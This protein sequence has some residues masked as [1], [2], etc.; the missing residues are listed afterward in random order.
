MEQ[1]ARRKK[2]AILSILAEADAPMGSRSIAE[3]LRLLGFDLKERMVRYYLTQLDDQGLTEDVGRAGRR[4]TRRGMQD[5]DA[6]L[7]VEKVGYASARIDELA[8]KMTFS[9]K[10]RRGSVVLNVSRFRAADYA[11]ASN[12]IGAVLGRGLGMGT[13][14]ALGRE[15]ESLG[16]HRIT[17][18][19]VGI[20]TVCSVTLNGAFRAAGIPI[21]ARLGGLLELSDGEP[22][23]FTQIIH[24]DGTTIDPV[25]VFLKGKLTRV[26]EAATT[27][28]G[29]IGAGFR[30]IPSAALPEARE[31]IKDLESAGLGC[32]LALGRPGRTLLGIPVCPGR[33]GIV[34]AAGL[35]AIAAVEEAGIETENHAMAAM[36]PFESLVPMEEM[37]GA[38][39]TSPELKKRL[40]SML[41]H[42]DHMPDRG[43]Y[44]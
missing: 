20:G 31:V 6:A 1:E 3:E 29:V 15:G 42:G 14:V 40:V 7:A 9:P 32:I 25:L 38:M 18:G 30:E 39:V 21:H 16:G 23:R 11:E 27:G 22:R 43:L 4:I 33:A 44:E 41:D 17:Y 19:E 36:G 26:H 5:L 2:H 35:N 24:Y 37:A 28:S 10:T 13:R 12:R 8:Y 34:V